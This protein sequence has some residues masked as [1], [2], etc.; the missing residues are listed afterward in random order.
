M[1]IKPCKKQSIKICNEVAKISNDFERENTELKRQYIVS[2]IIMYNQIVS[3][4]AENMGTFGTGYPFY[5]LDKNLE[6]ALPVIDEQIRYNDELASIADSSNLTEWVCGECLEETSFIMPDLKQVCKPCPNVP[7]GLKPRKIINRLPDID[8]WMI[9]DSKDIE[10]VK[11]ELEQLLFINGMH[12]S[13]VDPIRTIFELQDIVSNLQNGI[14]PDKYLPIDTHIID[15]ASLYVLVELIPSALARS[16]EY[17][18]T[19]YLPIHPLSLRKNWQYDDEAYNFIHD[20]LSSFS[21]FEID[22]EL[23]ELI[24]KTRKEIALKYSFDTLYDFLIRSGPESVK[25]RHETPGLKEAFKER[26]EKW[27]E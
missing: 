12:T 6:G 15:R 19:P 1:D 8:M 5:I 24:N 11:T 17:N 9:C 27:K 3:Q 4:I 14:K 25:R 7:N 21:E 26:I 23:G 20:F 2:N 22:G 18:M 13:D 10:K 16:Y